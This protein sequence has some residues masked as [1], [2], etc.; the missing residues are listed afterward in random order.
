MKQVIDG[1]ISTN[2]TEQNKSLGRQSTNEQMMM[3]MQPSGRV[4]VGGDPIYDCYKLARG[5]KY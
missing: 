5:C 4:F 2:V 1:H 3:M